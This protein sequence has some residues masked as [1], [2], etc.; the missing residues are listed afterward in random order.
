M[1]LLV[2]FNLL[3]LESALSIARSIE[4]QVDLFTVGPLLLYKH[5][6]AAVERFKEALPE[7][8]LVVEAQILERPQESVNL[9]SDAGASW[10]S[11]MAGAGQKVITTACSTARNKGTKIVLDLADASSVGQ[12][13]L[14]AQ[15]FGAVALSFH[16]PS[17]DDSR[18]PFIDRWHM[19][20]GNTELPIFVSAHI[21]RENVGE[22]LGLEPSGIIIGSSV[23][24]A[25]N[26][27]EEIKYFSEL[28]KN[29]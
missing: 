11:V 29:N 5:G 26:P 7:I 1:K 6:V 25:D 15:R 2:A 22:I 14:D 19:V 10:I 18:V 27:L 4:Q 28:V 16:K 21:S 8:P 3:D 23:V 9:F 12:S 20:K 17:V 24:Q 13:A